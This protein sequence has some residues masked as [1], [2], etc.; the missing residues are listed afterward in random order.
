MIKKSFLLSK[1]DNLKKSLI[2]DYININYQDLQRELSCISGR[3]NTSS[4][5]KPKKEQFRFNRVRMV[6]NDWPNHGRLEVIT[7]LFLKLNKKS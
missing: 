5:L 7:D 3:E 6:P 1:V 2:K 4:I